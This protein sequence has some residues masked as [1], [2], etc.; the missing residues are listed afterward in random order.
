M[1][2]ESDETRH[3]HYLLAGIACASMHK[4]K[5]R[6][7]IFFNKKPWLHRLHG[8]FGFTWYLQ[9]LVVSSVA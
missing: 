3:T 9:F 8:T 4:S 5:K 1:A 6:G 7:V 2:I